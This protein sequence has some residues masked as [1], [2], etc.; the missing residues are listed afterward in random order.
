MSAIPKSVV[1]AFLAIGMAILAGDF[2][3]IYIPLSGWILQSVLVGVYLEYLGAKRTIFMVAIMEAFFL[4]S[5]GGSV[6]VAAVVSLFSSEFFLPVLIL[7][8]FVVIAAVLLLGCLTN[9]VF[10]RIRLFK[11]INQRI[12]KG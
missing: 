5:Y 3:F 12:I 1:Y 10:R 2:L 9:Y 6:A 11:R 4:A 7:L 8:Y